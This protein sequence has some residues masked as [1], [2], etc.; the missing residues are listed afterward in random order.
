[1]VTAFRCRS[2]PKDDMEWFARKQPYCWPPKKVIEK[3]KYLGFLVVPVGHPNSIEKDKEWRIS[4]SQQERLLVTLFSSVQLK[5]FGLM[6]VLKN[7]LTNYKLKGEIL[8]SYHCKTCM[9]YMV[10]TTP[11]EFWIPSNLIK[12]ITTCLE[13]LHA[14]AKEKYCPNYFIP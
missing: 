14:W 5:C 4:L 3:C 2:L 12:C 7:E 9:L 13:K 8:T 10:E 6:K 1:M 11:K